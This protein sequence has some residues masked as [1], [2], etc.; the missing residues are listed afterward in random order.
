MAVG[1]GSIITALSYVAVGRESTFKTYNTAA[2]GLDVLSSSFKTTKE[3]KILEEIT[4]SR[5]YSKRISTSKKIE[6][7]VE[8]YAYAESTAL[9]YILQNS[10]GGTI[11]SATAT[12]ETAGGAAFTHT[13]AVGNFDQANSSLCINHRKGDSASAYVF[14]YSGVRV[15]E[16]SVVSEIDEA[17]K[18]NVGAMIVNS[19]QTSN[20]VCSV[21]STS[22]FQPLS[23]VNG[24]ISIEANTLGAHTTTSFWHVQSMELGL[25]NSLKGDAESGRIG[26]DVLD[27][28]P[29]GIASFSLNV[30]MRFNT[31]TAYNAMLNE[32]TMS[33]SFEFLG[34]TLGTS[35]IPRGLKFNAPKLFIAEAGDPEIGGPDGVLTS[36]VVFHVL[37]DE[38]S[39]GGY[40]LQA[41]LTNDVAS[42]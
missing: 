18:M 28:L 42:Y 26:S 29:P 6:G 12:G 7:T 1:D 16:F 10:F 30:K 2:A 22:N 9:A 27:V 24:R 3:N 40:A 20:D 39:A 14:E 33:G 31:L 8:A 38:S 21:L 41:E 5:T 25:N 37:R 35:V 11:T 23:F 36:E 15:N 34:D 4:K 13:F 32:T 17:L 19:T